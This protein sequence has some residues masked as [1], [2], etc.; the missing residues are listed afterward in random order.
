LIKNSTSVHYPHGIIKLSQHQ[1]DLL[2]KKFADGRAAWS[3]AEILPS[4]TENCQKKLHQFGINSIA[5]ALH[6]DLY[7]H[8]VSKII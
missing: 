3:C 8:T 1:N 6:S 5:A 4:E 7:N 2:E